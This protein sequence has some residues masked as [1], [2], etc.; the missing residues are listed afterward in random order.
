MKIKFHNHYTNLITNNKGKYLCIL[1]T[2]KLNLFLEN[3]I[4]KTKKIIKKLDKPINILAGI[5][6]IWRVLN[7]N[8]SK[9]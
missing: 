4:M 8:I 2:R 7:G 6:T 3:K 9:K 5:L 1:K